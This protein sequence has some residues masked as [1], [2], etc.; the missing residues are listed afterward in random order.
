MQ[1]RPCAKALVAANEYVLKARPSPDGSC[2]VAGLSNGDVI[3][4][5]V[6]P[7]ALVCVSRVAAAHGQ[8]L[9]EVLFPLPAA[10]YAL[11]SAGGDGA[12]R[13]WDLRTAPSP[14]QG[15]SF[16]TPPG[17]AAL[18]SL[19]AEDNL[20]AAGAA[21]SVFCW[22]R[23]VS[24]SRPLAVLDDTH[25]EDVAAVALCGAMLLSG[26]T[27]GLIAVHDTSAVGAQAHEADAGFAAAL[28][29]GTS[30]EALGLF[31][32]ARE[33]L[34][35]RTSTETSLLWD[36][37][38]ASRED[39]SSGGGPLADIADARDQ[40]TAAWAAAACGSCQPV[41]S[42]L[43]GCHFDAASR[44]LLL[45]AGTSGGDAAFFPLLAGSEGGGATA[46]LLPPA[47]VL[48]GGHSD[49]VRSVECFA[50]VAGQQLLCATGG[51]DGQVVLWSANA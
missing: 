6:T 36:W 15:E 39:C 3:V 2:V 28:N 22:D 11:L 21:G 40:A 19:A 13:S 20:I 48:T 37:A 41:V 8:K 7:S 25:P 18:F 16:K 46:A 49:V 33:R 51:E 14:H 30:V 44:Q 29:V 27:D 17:T 26:S 43:V 47:V 42:Y 35:C 12:V 45:I 5:A 32:A 23:R 38:A 34:W 10:P 4:Y 50:G 24:G 1:A 31:G 9:A